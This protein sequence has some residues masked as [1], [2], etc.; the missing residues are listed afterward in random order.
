MLLANGL[1]T[2]SIKS[3][4]VFSESLPKNSAD[5]P[6]LWNWGFDNFILAKNLFSKDLRSFECTG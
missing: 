3:N 4:P 2:F 6:I 1:S 5:C